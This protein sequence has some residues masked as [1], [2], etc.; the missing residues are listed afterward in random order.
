M[1]LKYQLPRIYEDLLPRGLLQ[2]E[3]LETKATCDQCIMARPQNKGKI[4]YTP[5]L[6]C[7]TFYPFLPNYIVGAILTYET[8]S[9]PSAVAVIRSKI[10][11]REYSLPLGL[12]APPNYQ[13]PYNQ[14]RQN[15]FGQREDWLCPYFNKEQQN[16]GIWRQRGAVCT[17]FYCKS[18]YGV[19]GLKFWDELSNYLTYVEM[20]LMEESLVMLDFSPRQIS[21]LLNY[22][23][24]QE[25]TKTEMKSSR[26]PE[27]RSRRLWNGYYEDQEA[28]FK[29]SFEIVKKLDKN[30]FRELLGEPGKQLEERLQKAF[31]KI[32]P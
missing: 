27:E 31:E 7:C 29:K 20:A 18:S 10:A 17:S 5:D 11:K 13:V 14:R 28:F 4:F 2:I 32:C 23:N 15:E 12:V 8:S 1:K 21:D 16:C 3:P 6:K 22:L 9:A 25:A 19:K 24:R 26:M 30:S